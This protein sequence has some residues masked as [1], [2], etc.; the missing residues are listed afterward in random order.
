MASG[1]GGA[2]TRILPRKVLNQCKPSALG[3]TGNHATADMNGANMAALLAI[4][5]HLSA[6][7]D[8]WHEDR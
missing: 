4:Y 7:Y 2:C 1:D 3:A 6:F 8:L 5:R